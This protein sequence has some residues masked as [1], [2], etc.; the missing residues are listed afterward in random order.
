MTFVLANSAMGTAAASAIAGVFF[1]V[2]GVA[3]LVLSALLGVAAWWTA[4]REQIDS[5]AQVFARGFLGVSSVASFAVGAV[6][7]TL[8][9][10]MFL[11][12]SGKDPRFSVVAFFLAMA[13]AATFL[14]VEFVIAG[15]LY[16]RVR[17]RS[18]SGWSRALSIGSFVTSG[19]LGF[20]ALGGFLFAALLAIVP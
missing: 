1:I 19:L 14:A 4:L 3:A 17:A 2:I 16:R 18:G 11:D 20:G 9:A 15:L 6:C 8:G 12:P 7:S 5:T 10:A 13:L